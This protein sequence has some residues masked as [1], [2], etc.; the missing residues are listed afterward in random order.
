MGWQEIALLQAEAWPV[1]SGLANVQFVQ[2]LNVLFG[3]MNGPGSLRPLRT[4]RAT[5]TGTQPAPK[6]FGGPSTFKAFPV[7]DDPAVI[8]IFN[9]K[10]SHLSAL[11][12]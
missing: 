10:S 2:W 8:T 3:Y 11:F 1:A 12:G 5:F 6:F 7:R 9:H 4:V